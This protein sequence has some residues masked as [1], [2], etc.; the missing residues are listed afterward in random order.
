MNADDHTVLKFRPRRMSHPS[1]PPAADLSNYKNEP[2]IPDD[3][4]HRMMTNAAAFAFVVLLAS[5]GIW[6]AVK[7]ADLRA[8]QDCVLMGR[9][10]CAHI[11][12]SARH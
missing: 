12:S 1:G 7:L 4:R 6:L 11:S 10:D 9:S 2:A 8:A 5:V 3:Y